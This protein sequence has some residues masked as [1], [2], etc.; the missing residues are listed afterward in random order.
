MSVTGNPVLTFTTLGSLNSNVRQATF[1]GG[2]GTSGLR[3]EYAVQVGDF[4]DRVAISANP[5]SLNGGTVRD[6]AGNDADFTAI[7]ATTFDGVFI[8]LTTV[9]AVTLVS[10]NDRY[11]RAGETILFD[12]AFTAPVTVTATPTLS[13]IVGSTTRNANYVSGSGTQTL[14]FAYTVAAGHDDPDGLQFGSTVIALASPATITNSGGNVL[15][16]F[17]PPDI[18]GLRV[19]AV[20]P[21]IALPLSVPAAGN[22][23]IGDVL[24]F[25]VLFNESLRVTPQAGTGQVPRIA[26][27]IGSTTQYATYVA[28]TE[29]P[30]IV[31]DYT[32]QAGD[33]DS[34]GIVVSTVI[35]LNGAKITD[36][37]GN[38][39]PLTFATPPTNGVL[40]DGVTPT[41][42]RFS[43]TKANGRY[44]VGESISIVATMSEMVQAGSAIEVTLSSGAT[45]LLAAA[46]NGNTL[47]GTYVVA[48]GENTA[49]LDVT[50]YADI[51][52]LDLF[53]N[54][55]GGTAL[56]TVPNSIGGARDI[57]IDTIAPTVLSFVSTTPDGFYRANTPAGGIA[58][59]ANVSETVRAGSSFNVTLDSGAVVTLSTIAQGTTLTG[60]YVIAAGQNSPDLTVASYNTGTLRDLAGNTF[61]TFTTPSAANIA[62]TSALVVDTTPPSAT[63][64]PTEQGTSRL[65]D[66][67]LN[68][69]EVTAGSFV[70][71]VSLSNS[72]ATEHDRVDLMLSGHNHGGQIRRL[73]HLAD[74]PDE[75]RHLW[76]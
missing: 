46:A 59:T 33:L 16:G 10:P 32:V 42:T 61:D 17:I 11:Y 63:V 41:V 74:R 64:A 70:V 45:Q 14:R 38:N 39:I 6:T 5:I 66:A 13:L 25:S 26:L 65:V 47:T 69:V 29:T 4:A 43:T 62:D 36:I 24:Q 58:I 40:V 19:D 8:N 54:P 22:Y 44:T 2:S 68:A 23:G 53:D 48:A 20:A 27:V 57:V 9:D 12:V 1:S 60:K 31:F 76:H 72:Q 37:A 21:T 15:L 7:T 28:G 52:V 73:H 34:N 3:F 50:S 75:R 49:D 18:T 35:S 51:G 56:P 55:L 71:R 30:T 67:Y